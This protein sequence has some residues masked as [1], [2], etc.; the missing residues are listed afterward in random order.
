MNRSKLFFVVF[1]T[2]F[3][4]AA[5]NSGGPLDPETGCEDCPPPPTGSNLNATVRGPGAPGG[6]VLKDGDQDASYFGMQIEGN[7][8]FGISHFQGV[9]LGTLSKG[10]GFAFHIPAID[11]VPTTLALRPLTDETEMNS[12]F[13]HFGYQEF[14]LDGEDMLAS[15]LTG[16][17]GTVTVLTVGAD[18]ISLAFSV[19][20][21]MTD[22]PFAGTRE[23]SGEFVAEKIHE[24]GND[25]RD[26]RKETVWR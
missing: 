5:C 6:V 24:W 10:S 12:P 18:R 11:Q 4:S 22:G 7:K 3:A 20:G 25:E 13:A 19:T 15:D 23:I 17:V 9:V 21:A 26:S 8:R 1:V 14:R 2:L 16:I